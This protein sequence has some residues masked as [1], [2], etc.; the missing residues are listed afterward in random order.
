M[1]PFLTFL[2]LVAFV[3]PFAV[4]GVLAVQSLRKR[5]QKSQALRRERDAWFDSKVAARRAV[6]CL[7]ILCGVLAVCCSAPTFAAD[8]IVVRQPFFRP[9]TTVIQQQRQQAI[10]VQPR[11]QIVVQP[12]QNFIFAQPQAFVLQQPQALFFQQPQAFTF[13]PQVEQF[14]L[15]GNCPSALLFGR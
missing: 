13:G 4:I 7:A 3:V 14:S 8:R 9:N 15:P 10:V 2:L 6:A 11:Q 12:R 1:S 5:R